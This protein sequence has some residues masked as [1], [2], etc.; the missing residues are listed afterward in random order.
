[1]AAVDIPLG[2][3]DQA[4]EPRLGG[5]QVVVAVVHQALGHSETEHEELALRVVQK[6]E[7]HLLAE[8][9]GGAGQGLQALDQSHGEGGCF[10]QPVLPI[11]RMGGDVV[12]QEFG[13]VAGRQIQAGITVQVR[14]LSRIGPR[15]VRQGL[16]FPGQAL[17]V[18]P[19]QGRTS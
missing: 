3:G 14:Q 2:D 15:Q 6:A 4:G 16:G 7:V 17:P 10:R 8:F 19:T 1:M 9:F 13:P 5:E 12:P 18:G 11:P